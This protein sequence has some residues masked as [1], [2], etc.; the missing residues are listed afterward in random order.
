MPMLFVLLLIGLY[1]LD[2]NTL[3]IYNGLFWVLYVAALVNIE[4]LA[5]KE[6]IYDDLAGL[7][8]AMDSTEE[9]ACVPASSEISGVPV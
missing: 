4:L 2:E 3:L 1:D 9:E 6:Q 7:L 8:A 5:V